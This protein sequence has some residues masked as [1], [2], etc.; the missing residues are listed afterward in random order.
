MLSVYTSALENIN[1]WMIEHFEGDR[2]NAGCTRATL[3]VGEENFRERRKSFLPLEMVVTAHAHIPYKP[4]DSFN[5]LAKKLITCLVASLER[6]PGKRP[7]ALN[8]L[9]L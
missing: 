5:Q 1:L 6:T 7:L 9:L 3:H 8:Y 4:C 2:P